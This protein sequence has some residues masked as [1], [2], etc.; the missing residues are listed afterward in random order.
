VPPHALLANPIDKRVQPI[1]INPE[2]FSLLKKSKKTLERTGDIPGRAEGEDMTKK[3]LTICK[4][5]H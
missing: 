4:T 5:M 1:N 2:A 3:M